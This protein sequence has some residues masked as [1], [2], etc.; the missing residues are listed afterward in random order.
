MALKAGKLGKTAMWIIMGLLFVGLAGFGATNLSGNVRTVG[1]VGDK[2]I[3][4]D[5][6][7]RA[8]QQELR[9]LSAQAGQ[10]V[11][12]RDVQQAG[13]TDQILAQ[14]V[15]TAALDHEAAALGISISDERLGREIVRIPAF[16][17]INGQFDRAA[18]TQALQNN[19]FNEAEFEEDLREETART[20]LQGAVLSG[21]PMPSAYADTVLG[22]VAETRD[23]TFARVD[24]NVLEAPVPAPTEAELAGF[25]GDS[26][27]AYTV[28]ETKVITYAWLRPEMLLDTVEID[29]ATLRDAYEANRAQYVQPERRLV[30][31]V[32]LSDTQAA[33][34]ARSAIDAGERSFEDVV[35]DRGLELSDVDMGDVTRDDLGAAADA[36]FGAD[37][38]QVVGPFATD[39]GPGLF[40]VNGILPEQETTFEQAEPILRETLAQDRARRVIETQAQ[41]Y[42]D[43]LAGGATLEELAQETDMVLGRIDWTELSAEG[44]AAYDAFRAA[45]LAL[46]Q[47][48]F[49]AIAELG[50]GGVFAL[51]L[52]EIRAPR[53]Q[54]LDEVRDQ[55]IADWTEQAT[56]NAVLEEAERLAGL[57]GE[58]RTF[59]AL[60]LTPNLRGDQGRRA[61]LV[62]LPPETMLDVFA[63]DRGRTTAI[64]GEGTEAIVLRLDQINAP[65]MSDPDTRALADLIAQQAEGQLGQDL[66]EALAR[67]IQR[68]AGISIDQQALNAV[69]TSFQ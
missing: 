12:F 11:S 19:G 62:D 43:L 47:D 41:E 14:L 59:E 56:Q 50:D 24:E 4:V 34:A 38:G 64:P 30:E 21:N 16:Q 23:F 42:D 45:A 37:Q 28:P 8:V 9:A 60:G 55:V 27:A 36:V 51:R 40:R 15:T 29:E 13:V 44:I 32:I 67:D 57:L 39:L 48:D 5:D 33:E 31:R 52:D 26:I 25:H 17:G 61:V 65:D 35:S 10:A 20:I 68:R 49:P 1:A 69:N 58:G 53:P 46:D 18:Y 6:Y 3:S 22:H 2:P 7:V 54:T 66:F 63:L